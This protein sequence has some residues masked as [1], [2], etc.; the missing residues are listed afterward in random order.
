M[1][2]LKTKH[3]PTPLVILLLIISSISWTVYETDW[4][5]SKQEKY[6]LY[7]TSADAG[8]EKEYTGLLNT[9][10]KAVELFFADTFKNKFAVY[11][12]PGRQ[13]LDS[14]WQTD[15]KMPT[16][17]SEC[18][19]VA[20]GVAQRLDMI[21]PKTWE[22]TA[23]EHTYSETVKTQQ[24]ITHEMVHVFHGQLNA[25]PDFSNAE[26]IDWFVEGLATYASGQCNAERIAEVKKAV[27]GKKTPTTLDKFWTGK[28]RYALS[29]S[30]I[31]YIESKY[32]RAKLKEI[33]PFNKKSGILQ[34][35]NITETEL[36]ANWADYITKL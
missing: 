5:T 36:L 9:G 10:A 7:Y 24:L 12:H 18:W 33:L 14:T 23:C 2:S 30:V 16:F 26:G 6:T 22:K 28:L 31:M 15:W 3:K 17:R 29:G 32:G 11:I 4:K 19:M 20:S 8:N 35:L 27:T 13:S 25:S 1:N 21:S 34:S